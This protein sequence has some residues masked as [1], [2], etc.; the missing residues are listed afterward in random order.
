MPET[1]NSSPSEVF[2]TMGF[3]D[4]QVSYYDFFGLDR[5]ATSTQVQEAYFS[6]LNRYQNG[7]EALY[8]LMDGGALEE[9]QRFAKRAF[10]VLMD[11]VKK[12]KYDLGQ[13][14]ELDMRPPKVLEPMPMHQEPAPHKTKKQRLR[15][16]HARCPEFLEKLSAMLEGSTCYDGAW[17]QGIRELAGETREAMQE[18]I[19]ISPDI[20]EALENNEFDRLPQP[21]YVKGLI[22]SYCKFLGIDDSKAI[23]AGYVSLLNENP[24][25]K[26]ST[27]WKKKQN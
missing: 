4:N 18:V 26:N 6:W 16:A 12:E 11:P 9:E 23:C 21:V 2:S 10:E 20:L 15:S 17:L 5:K 8:S 27:K 22:K 24:S 13:I 14:S 3:S 7:N 1:S 19:K 25:E